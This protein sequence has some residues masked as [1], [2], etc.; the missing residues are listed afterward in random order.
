[1]TYNTISNNADD[2]DV[3]IHCLSNMVAKNQSGYIF[4]I[5]SFKHLNRLFLMLLKYIQYLKHLSVDHINGNP[6]LSFYYIYR[7]KVKFIGLQKIN[8]NDPVSKV[9]KNTCFERQL[10]NMYRFKISNS[11]SI[12]STFLKSDIFS[13]LCSILS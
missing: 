13:W 2:K 11:L 12:Q 3:P 8:S 7:G 10:S 5:R 6:N 1:L 9:A 4:P